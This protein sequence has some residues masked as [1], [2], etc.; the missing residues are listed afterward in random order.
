M[1]VNKDDITINKNVL[2]MSLN[3]DNITINKKIIECV[4]N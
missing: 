4:F 1:S 3:K 2:S